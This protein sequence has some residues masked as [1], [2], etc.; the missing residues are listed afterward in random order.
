MFIQANIGRNVN[1]TPMSEDKWDT[2][3]GSVAFAIYAN[4]NDVNLDMLDIEVHNGT[5]SF[6]G[7][8]EDSRHIS[9]YSEAG[10]DLDN[11]RDDLREIKGWYDQEAIALIVGSELI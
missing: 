8:S 3:A 9:V 6:E 2:F 1:D 7:I 5:G 10:F 11:L 4:A